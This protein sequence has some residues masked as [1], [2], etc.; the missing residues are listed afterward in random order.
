MAGST[1][2]AQDDAAAGQAAD[3]VDPVA[4]GG[5]IRSFLGPLALRDYRLFLGSSAGSSV[6]L[7]VHLTT[8][9]GPAPR[10]TASP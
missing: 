2:P 3:A 1:Q 6:G 4:Q 9:G 10:R 7:W 8:M 5:G